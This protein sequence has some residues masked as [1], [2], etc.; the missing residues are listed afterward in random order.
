MKNKGF[1]LVE[2]LVVIAIVG[3]VLIILIPTISNS[4]NERKQQ[5]YEQLISIFESAAALYASNASDDIE[6]LINQ[7]GEASISL[8]D[9]VRLKY[10]K[11]E[12]INPIDDSVIPDTKVIIIGKLDRAF[13]YCYEDRTDCENYFYSSTLA[14]QIKNNLVTKNNSNYFV[15]S[16]PNNWV[17]FGQ[18]SE[19]DT[20]PLMWRIVRSDNDGIRLIYEGLKNG[21]SQPTANGAVNILGS[22]TL[23]FNYADNKLVGSNIARLLSSW[24][25]SILIKN[26]E[27]YLQPHNWCISGIPNNNPTTTKIFL[28]KECST[29]NDILSGTYQGTT[30]EATTYSLLKTSDYINASGNSS[31]TGSYQTSGNNN[32]NNCASSNYLY[33]SAYSWWTANANSTSKTTVWAVETTGALTSRE[34]SSAAA[35]RPVINVRPTVIYNSGDG[36]LSSPYKIKAAIRSS[37]DKT[38]PV[39]T[40]TGSNPYYLTD[41]QTFTDPGAT[42]I[43]YNDGDIT[44]S[45]VKVSTVVNG[46]IG[47]YKVTYTSTDASG[48]SVTKTR[49]VYITS[50]SAPTLAFGTNG[51]TTYAKSRSTTVTVSDPDGVNASSLKYLW[52]T[53]TV[54]PSYGDFTTSFTNGGTISSPA[55]VSGG[56]YLWIYARDNLNNPVITRSNVFNLDNTPPTI[57]INGNSTVSFTTGVY[58]SS[59]VDAGAIATD[60]RVPTDLT[61]SIVTVNSVNSSVFGTYTVT[62]NVSDSAGNAGTQVIRTVNVSTLGIEYLVVGGG[63]GGGWDAG[64]GGGGGG[65][66]TGTYTASRTSYGVTV[67]PGGAGGPASIGG[68][69]SDGGSSAIFSIT[70]LG[71]AGAGNKG[72]A[73]RSGA[74][75]GGGGHS[76]TYGGGSGTAGQGYAGGTGSSTGG[77]GGGGAGSAG[78]TSTGNGGNGG[79]GIASSITGTATYYGGGGGGGHYSNT[80][81]LGGTGGLGGGGNGGGYSTSGGAGAANTGGG[82]GAMG[83]ATYTGGPYAGGSGVVIVRYYGSQKATGGTITSVGGYTIHTFTVSG[84]FTVN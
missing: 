15:G 47:T 50:N 66:L 24:Y 5:A 43:D 75:G 78:T 44:S 69:A 21:T 26:S 74:S 25:N 20:T 76:A 59:Y 29:W 57:T 11:E 51:N 34:M 6:Y 3:L 7:N 52:N 9:L 31:C 40:L 33:K 27:L 19:T 60:N 68:Q 14:N 58:G 65:V 32:G 73:G 4:V 55:G 16:N 30:S 53:S 48:N 62:Y 54:E 61:S 67:G 72:A 80:G 70:A 82:G 37:V 22:T 36:S 71:G 38:A 46:V 81:A 18:A 42:A 45:I 1:T 35:V 64:G 49:I 63:G 56:Y 83:N 13:G 77:G 8:A 39:L 41:I 28:E 79:N 12:L 10:L 84:T 17:E 23:K 2:L